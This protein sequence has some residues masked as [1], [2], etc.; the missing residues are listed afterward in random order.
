MTEDA[1]ADDVGGQ[2]RPV[3]PNHVQSVGPHSHSPDPFSQLIAHLTNQRTLAIR[4][5][6]GLHRFE[7]RGLIANGAASTRRARLAILSAE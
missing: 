7:M 3:V 2:H 1:V 4:L 5:S 6:F